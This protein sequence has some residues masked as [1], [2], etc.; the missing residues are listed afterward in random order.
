[1]IAIYG[2]PQCP[3]CEKAKM[4]CESRGLEYVYKTLGTDYTKEQLIEQFPGA[5]AVPQI[6]VDDK[7]IG[8]FKMFLEHLESTNQTGASV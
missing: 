1:M 2:K 7:P 5:R 4:F 6:T 8:T 3:E